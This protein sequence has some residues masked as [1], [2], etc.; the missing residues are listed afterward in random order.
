MANLKKLTIALGLSLS[1][2][3]AQRACAFDPPTNDAQRIVARMNPSN[4]NETTYGFYC[5]INVNSKLVSVIVPRN[6]ISSGKCMIHFHG[7]RVA[8]WDRT[9]SGTIQYFKFVDSLYMEAPDTLMIAPVGSYG[10]SNYS[11]QRDYGELTQ[12]LKLLDGVDARTDETCASIIVSGHSAAYRP[13]TQL[14][15]NAN[16]YPSNRFSKMLKNVF[17]FDALYSSSVS[18]YS[19]WIGSSTEHY[20]WNVSP[21]GSS[22][23]P[24]SLKIA[25][26]ARYTNVLSSISNHWN[27]VRDRYFAEFLRGRKIP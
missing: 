21:S 12:N 14:L 22:T 6:Y 2:F 11:L 20:A 9:A 13:I 26:S 1:A 3:A 24:N 19:K 4:C 7:L 10:S 17:L 23:R 5:Y 18:G 8:S 25:K 27:L 15:G 16:N